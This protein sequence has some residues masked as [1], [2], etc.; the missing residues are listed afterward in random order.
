M[1][2]ELV[3][4]FSAAITQNSTI[5]NLINQVVRMLGGSGVYIEDQTKLVVVF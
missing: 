5:V 4:K 3:F 1:S 2:K